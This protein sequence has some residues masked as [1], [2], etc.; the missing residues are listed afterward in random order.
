MRIE[1][2]RARL[3]LPWALAAAMTG[4]CA[5]RAADPP[6]AS[7]SA[8]ELQTETTHATSAPTSGPG[9]VNEA[10][11]SP[12]RFEAGI[13]PLRGPLLDEV[14]D[15]NWHPGCPVPIADLLVA[16][17]RYWGFD[18]QVHEGPL[19]L[20]EA[21]ADDVV[22]VF[23]RLFRAGFPIKHIA[24]ARRYRPDADRWHST[25]D[26]TA[27]FNCRPVTDVPGSVSQHSYGWAVDINPL[28]NPYVRGDGSVLRKAAKP[29]RDRSRRRRGMIHPGD[30]VVRSFARIGW[31]WG[32]DYTSIKDYMHFSL[33]GN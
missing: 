31:A 26:T 28:Q 13:E 3:L 32:G 10:P 27:S 20:N 21:V 2:M 15:R 18:G 24:L 19:V 33:T 23:R 6:P 22:G 9:A 12:P 14:M 11:T 30:I 25:R 16:H 29:Y 8:N 5:A 1:A 17:V 4:G 7:H